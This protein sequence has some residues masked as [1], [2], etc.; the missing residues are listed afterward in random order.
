MNKEIIGNFLSFASLALAF[1]FARSAR[2]HGRGVRGAVLQEGARL[3][4]ARPVGPRLGD[5][6][7]DRVPLLII[8]LEFPNFDDK[9]IIWTHVDLT[10]ALEKY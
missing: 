8:L 1:F 10:E 7:G 9:T 6:Q 2:A 5:T 4:P 3:L